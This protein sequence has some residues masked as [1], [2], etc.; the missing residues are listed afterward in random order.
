MNA[1]SNFVYVLSDNGTPFY[2]G[3]LQKPADVE[4][5]VTQGP[6]SWCRA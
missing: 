6:A 4:L 5:H 3:H 1:R 2:C